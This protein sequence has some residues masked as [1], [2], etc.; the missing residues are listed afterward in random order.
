MED[1]EI[2]ILAGGRG[3]R[4]GIDAP[5]IFAPLAGTTLI[6]YLLRTISG[7]P[8][9]PILVVGHRAEEV[10]GQLGEKYKYAF[11]SDPLGTGH[12]VM[13]AKKAVS[14]YFKNVV[15]LY[16]DMPFVSAN[17]IE[18]LVDLRESEEALFSM[19]TVDVENYKDWKKLFYRYGRIIRDKNGQLKAIREFKEA[20]AKEK[21]KTEVNPA[22]FCFD[23]EWLWENLE[24]VPNLYPYRGEYYL[25]DLVEI[26][27]SQ[28]AKIATL[29]IP[30][31]EA[32]GANTPEDLKILERF[33]G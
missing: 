18:K 16:G 14:L 6:E 9:A 5:K 21:E 33:V 25:T 23:S 7:F 11:Q 28:R 29:E 17:T 19:A 1:T 26:A 32:L 12:A 30:A 8:R 4:M 22:Y 31:K 10:R 13:C 15:V 24:K 27:V 3:D 20:S 2:I